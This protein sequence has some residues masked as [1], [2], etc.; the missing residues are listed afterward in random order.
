MLGPCVTVRDSEAL[1]EEEGEARLGELC[2]VTE[3]VRLARVGVSM[4]VVETVSEAEPLALELAQALE[5]C[6]A[7]AL[8]VG[9]SEAREALGRPETEVEGDGDEEGVARGLHEAEPDQ[10]AEGLPL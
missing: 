8:G 7:A 9:V 10:E 3:A 2:A 5:L 6:D 4:A 1:L